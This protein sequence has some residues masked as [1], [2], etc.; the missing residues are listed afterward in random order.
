MVKILF[1]WFIEKFPL[2]VNY[3]TP[4]YLNLR[5]FG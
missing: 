1:E 4:I 3:I 5:S 2:I